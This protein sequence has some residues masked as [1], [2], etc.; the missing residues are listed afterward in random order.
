MYAGLQA[1]GNIL[2]SSTADKKAIVI[3]TDGEAN[4][5]TYDNSGEITVAENYNVY[6]NSL[7]I[8]KNASEISSPVPAAKR[9]T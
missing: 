3:M 4:M 9:E 7:S 5:G 2:G 1:A 8:F 6:F